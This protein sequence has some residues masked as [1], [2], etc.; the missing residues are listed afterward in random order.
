V[1]QRSIALTY[2]L[3]C[4]FIVPQGTHKGPCRRH[5]R[6]G[7]TDEG[8]LA[9]SIHAHGSYQR[10]DRA[11]GPSSACSSRRTMTERSTL[12]C[13]L[14]S[15][16]ER[17]AE[18]QIEE[19]LCFR[20][21]TAWRQYDSDQNSCDDKVRTNL[22]WKVPA[23]CRCTTACNLCHCCLSL[24]THRAHTGHA[25]LAPSWVNTPNLS[26]PCGRKALGLERSSGSLLWI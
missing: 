7:R 15:W 18:A 22:S 17:K 1:P 20:A 4:G 13:A 14:Q 10:N 8:W 9:R 2:A 21:F 16:L 3:C 19:T 11:T 6:D 26:Y 5:E 25:L 23:K 12:S 24:I